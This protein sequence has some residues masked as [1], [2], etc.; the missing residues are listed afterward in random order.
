MPFTAIDTF[1]Y[2]EAR[3][4]IL[5]SYEIYRNIEPSV[6]LLSIPFL[7]LGTVFLPGAFVRPNRRIS[8]KD[9]AVYNGFLAACV[10]SAL[11]ITWFDF[12]RGGVCLRYL[13]DFAWLLAIMSAV[14]LLRRIMRKS[15]R[16]TVYGLIC[17]ALVLTFFTVFFVMLAQDSSNLTKLYPSLLERCED[18]FIFWH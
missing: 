9:A 15:G 7:L 12:S 18:F 2:F 13:T 4:I 10:L 1:P 16:K 5:N 17:A 6:G 8:Q 14:V 3:G 11:F